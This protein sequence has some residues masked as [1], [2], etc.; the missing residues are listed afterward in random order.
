MLLMRFIS[1]NG[2]LTKSAGACAVF[3]M[4]KNGLARDP[5]NTDVST[6]TIIA[7]P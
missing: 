7:N 1:K 4:I 5:A 3:H 2:P 6:S